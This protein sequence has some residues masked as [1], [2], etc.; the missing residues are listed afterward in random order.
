[1]A[2]IIIGV[3]VVA[4][5]EAQQAFIMSNAW[6]NHAASGA[7]LA[8]EIRELTRRLPK[9]DPVYG[10]WMDDDGLGGES[11]VGWGPEDGELSVEDFDDIDDFD[12]V[13]F[14]DIGTVGLDDGDLPGPIDAFG[15]VI[16]E[17]AIDGEVVFDEEDAMV[18]MVGWSQQVIVTKVGS[19][20]TGTVLADDARTAQIGVGEYPLR[21]EVV[22]TYQ[23]QWATAPEEVTRVA[24][25]VP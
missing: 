9:H 6:S 18:P 23:G 5:I 16:P 3:G 19:F 20:D 15:N 24:W 12:G 22:V 13:I 25:I 17:I 11:L 21:V 8:E 7:L 4:M 14:A 1:M 10:V 2:T